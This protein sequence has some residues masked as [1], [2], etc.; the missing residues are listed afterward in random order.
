M[1][2]DITASGSEYS[3]VGSVYLYTLDRGE[4]VLQEPS[5]VLSHTH[6]QRK[7]IC[8]ICCCHSKD[9]LT[10]YFLLSGICHIRGKQCNGALSGGGGG[11]YFT[12][13]PVLSSHNVTRVKHIRLMLVFFFT[14]E[15]PLSHRGECLSSRRKTHALTRGQINP[16]GVLRAKSWPLLPP[17]VPAYLI[18]HTF[19]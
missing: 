19:I 17:P 7:Y 8:T 4:R 5:T 6:G 13:L 10:C 15:E 16:L 12:Q 14:Q 9:M 3:I 2:R 11:G 18:K 1:W